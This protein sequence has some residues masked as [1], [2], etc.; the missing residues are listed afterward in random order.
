MVEIV[1]A[2]VLI[3][4]LDQGKTAPIAQGLSWLF[5]ASLLLGKNS[6][7]SALPKS[8]TPAYTPSNLVTTI[9]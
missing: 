5:L 9:F 4:F 7:L 6:I 1:G 8:K 2:V 3:S